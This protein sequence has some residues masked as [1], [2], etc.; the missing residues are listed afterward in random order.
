[1]KESQFTQENGRDIKKAGL[2]TRV[3]ASAAGAAM[4]LTGC[5]VN[6]EP[7]PTSTSVVQETSTPTPSITEA[8]PSP[9]PTAVETEAPAST[10]YNFEIP[11]E[12]SDRLL[13]LPINELSQVEVGDRAQYAL[14]Y[15]DQLDI[16]TEADLYAQITTDSKDKLPETLSV[17]NTPQE[18][19]AWDAAITRLM[20]MVEDPKD[21][22]FFDRDVAEKIALSAT[23]NSATSAGYAAG[24]NAINNAL[25]LDNGMSKTTRGMAVSDYMSA[26]EAVGASEVYTAI[27][28]NP[29]I[30]IEVRDATG[31]IGT[32][33]FQFV[34]LKNGSSV[35]LQQ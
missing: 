20:F 28:D 7:T 10:S 4:L 22:M 29:A 31:N 1:M 8:A 6:A 21:S 5:S 33:T 35:W 16:K 19:L 2:W 26:A 13:S 9:T 25:T 34:T 14:Y 27:T 18:I 11:K 3:A 24:V 15:A 23:V 17:D 32:A 30:D 12:T